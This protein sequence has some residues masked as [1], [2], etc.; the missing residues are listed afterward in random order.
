MSHPSNLDFLR[1][2]RIA[3]FRT[4]LYFVATEDPEIDIGC[5]QKNGH[6]VACDK[7]ISRYSRSL[8]NLLAS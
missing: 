7:I 6:D 1:E 3:S 5:V 4:Y 2:A 8:D